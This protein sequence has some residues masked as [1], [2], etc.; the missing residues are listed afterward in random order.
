MLHIQIQKIKFCCRTLLIFLSIISSYQSSTIS[1]PSFRIS[2]PGIQDL[3]TANVQQYNKMSQIFVTLQK[4]AAEIDSLQS[5]RQDVETIKSRLT[6]NGLYYGSKSPKTSGKTKGLSNSKSKKNKSKTDECN[7]LPSTMTTTP[8]IDPPVEDLSFIQLRI[9][10]LGDSLTKGQALHGT[11][12]AYR[13]HLYTMLTNRG[14]NVDYVGTQIKTSV[15]L[16]DKEH[17]GVGGITISSVSE[18]IGDILKEIEVPDIILLHVGTNDFGK[19]IDIFT[20]VDRYEKLI[21]KISRISPT[22]NIIA[23]S[24]LV[25]SDEVYDQIQR[26]F[27]NFIEDTI[28]QQAA[29]GVKVT[30]LDMNKIVKKE[31]LVDGIHPNYEGYRDM[32]TA[33]LGAI[34]KVASPVGDNNT[35]SILSAYAKNDKQIVVTLSKPIASD[36]VNDTNNYSLDNP[37]IKIVNSKLDVSTRNILL[38]TTSLTPYIGLPLV[39]IIRDGIKDRTDQMRP[40]PPL[41]SITITIRFTPPKLSTGSFPSLNVRIM[42]LGSTLTKGEVEFPGSYRKQVYKELT[43]LGYNVDFVGTKVTN[44]FPG[45]DEH[46]EGTAD[47]YITFFTRFAEFWLKKIDT[48]DVILLHVGVFDFIR[49]IDVANAPSRYSKLI[50]EIAELRPTSRIIATNLISKKGTQL[51]DDIQT[52]FNPFIENIVIENASNGILVNYLDIASFIKESDV[53]DKSLLTQTGYDNMGDAWVSAITKYV[54][55]NGDLTSK[56]K[57]LMVEIPSAKKNEII[58]TFSKPISDVSAELSSNYDL[59]GLGVTIKINNIIVKEDKRVVTLLTSSL[60]SFKGIDLIITVK[61]IVDLL[62][63]QMN[64]HVQD[65]FVPKDEQ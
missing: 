63:N 50:Q 33:W 48:P 64:E 10:P 17:E 52:Y 12:G 29:K 46:H 28:L 56:P 13:G 11:I 21:T 44:R 31:Q 5:L 55:P 23:T 20:A 61:G 65:L 16:A 53:D 14:Y 41:S 34:Q 27:N 6:L 45:I 22:S 38:T 37:D 24:L 43:K 25:R 39:V 19:D 2:D 57:V 54:N 4:I 59:T 3:Q 42:P 32:A 18:R 9:L 58:L 15:G 30:Y 51:Y 35:P 7:C 8:T 1:P 47:K 62:G 49:G 26:L 40:L 36:S 60:N